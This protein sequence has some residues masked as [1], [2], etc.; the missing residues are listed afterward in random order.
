MHNKG[1][2]PRRFVFEKANEIDLSAASG[3]H[4]QIHRT[5]PRTYS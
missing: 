1:K 2:T 5:V 4:C 3:A